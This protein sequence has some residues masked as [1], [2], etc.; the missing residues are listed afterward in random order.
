MVDLFRQI[1]ISGSD[2]KVVTGEYGCC[3]TPFD[4]EN[5][6]RQV[7]P[8]VLAPG[9]DQS[10]Y[11]DSNSEASAIGSIVKKGNAFIVEEGDNDKEKMSLPFIDFL[12]VRAT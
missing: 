2:E 10:G 6:F 12:G 11:S 3:Q 4:S 5:D 1:I 9:T 7:S 8:L